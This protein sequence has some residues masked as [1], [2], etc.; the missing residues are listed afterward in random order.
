MMGREEMK[1]SILQYL[2]ENGSPF[3]AEDDVLSWWQGLQ[4]L[5]D[6]LDDLT[7]ALEELEAR[8][9]IEREELDGGL[10]VYRIVHEG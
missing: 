8:G 10:F 6:S 1:R 7:M 4:G 5:T 3:E 9:A 2:E